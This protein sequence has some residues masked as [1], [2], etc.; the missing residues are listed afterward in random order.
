MFTGGER[1]E[2]EA[3]SLERIEGNYPWTKN[4]RNSLQSPNKKVLMSLIIHVPCYRLLA[5]F[6]SWSNYYI[7]KKK[8][9]CATRELVNRMWQQTCGT[10]LVNELSNDWKGKKFISHFSIHLLLHNLQTDL[11]TS[12]LQN[13][14]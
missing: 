6:Y 4:Y 3:I 1:A 12:M 5:M 8:R 14:L 13:L 11:Q 7:S 9:C 2:Y 10:F